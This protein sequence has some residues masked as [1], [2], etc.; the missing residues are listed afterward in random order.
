M[1]IRD[2][3][4]AFVVDHFYVPA[5]L[6]LGDGDSLLDQGIVDS[7]GVLEIIT[8]LE[9]R[10]GFA[11]EDSEVVPENLDSIERISAYAARKRTAGERP[12]A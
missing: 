1:D 3:V 11:V 7:T 2:E 5:E 12:A 8:F 9:E 10:F 6:R 4:R